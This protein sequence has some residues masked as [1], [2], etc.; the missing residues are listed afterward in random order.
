MSALRRFA[1][2]ACLAL[3]SCKQEAEAPPGAAQYPASTTAGTAPTP[4]PG[5]VPAPAATAPAM[6]PAFG[7]FCA[8]DNDAQ[9]PFAHCL[10]GRCGGCTNLADCKP[11]T[12]CAP[13]LLGQLCLPA[14]APA[15]PSPVPV[16][17]PVNVP[18][19][20]PAA[21]PAPTPAP[22]PAPTSSPL[23][24]ARNLCV[25][26]TNEY[27]A[28]V[29]IAPVARRSDAEACGDA[30]ARADAAS[31]TAHGAFGQCRERAQNEC[32]GWPGAPEDVI[33]RCLA[34]MFAEG[35]GAGPSHGHY[36]NM[37]D[38]KYR[39]VSCGITTLPSGELWVVQNFYP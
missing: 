27:R 24:S 13:T 6:P 12:Q 18:V 31:R 36:T 9:C 4:A 11:G 8:T 19:P 28:R 5:G 23:E 7:L 35:P 2:L 10:G 20:V 25:Q 29:G 38:A 30:Q 34:M 32:P 37:T 17:V 22:A 3:V 21:T 39:G 1:A 14:P 15:P 26:R 16:N 33:N